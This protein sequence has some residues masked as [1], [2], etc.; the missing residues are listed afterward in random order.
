MNEFLKTRIAVDAATYFLR[1]QGLVESGLSCKNWEIAETIHWLN[2]G[3]II[4]LGSDGSVVLQNAVKLGLKGRKVGVD[5]IYDGDKIT[6]D[7]IELYKRDAMDTQ[8]DGGVFDI[9]TCLSVIEHDVKYDKIAKEVSW[10]L[11]TGGIAII[12]FDYAEPK[13]NTEKMRLYNLD[14]N[15]LDKSDVLQLV[16]Q[17]SFNGIEL[18]SEIDWETQDMVINKF[19]CAPTDVEYTFGILQFIKK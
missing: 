19:Y 12:S 3:N 7:G 6:E 16:N 18:T 2:D 15:I 8:L 4:D 14:W 17:F 10:L 9:V 1:G 11:K 5:I 13:P